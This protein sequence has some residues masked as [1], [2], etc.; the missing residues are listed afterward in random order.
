MSEQFGEENVNTY[1]VL[2]SGWCK[3]LFCV[4]GLLTGCFFGCCC[5]CFCCFNCCCNY[6]CGKCR[7]EGA[8]GMGQDGEYRRY[9]EY[10][11]LDEVS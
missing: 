3:A 8:R 1:F 4:T 9:A 7:P 10:Q 2:T 11:N 6:C 5:G